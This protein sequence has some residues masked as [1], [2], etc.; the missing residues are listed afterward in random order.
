[1]IEET[2]IQPSLSEEDIRVY[3]QQVIDEVKK[4][5]IIFRK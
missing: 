2:G 4:T 1:M 5:K 3:L